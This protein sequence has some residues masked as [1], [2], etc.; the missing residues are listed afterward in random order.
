M[1][2]SFNVSGELSRS[3]AESSALFALR[4]RAWV[5]F[6]RPGGPRNSKSIKVC[7][8]LSRMQILRIKQHCRVISIKDGNLMNE[9]GS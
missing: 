8:D 4:C 9:E 6:I 7:A 2:Y 1:S 5:C 3:P